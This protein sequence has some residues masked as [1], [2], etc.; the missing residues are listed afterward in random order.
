MTAYL[1]A[2]GAALY[3]STG[4]NQG[5]NG[6]LA[7]WALEVINAD[8]RQPRPPRRLA[9]GQGHHRLRRS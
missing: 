4:V 1:A 3:A 8:H 6:T 7:F 9:H 5:R 2:D